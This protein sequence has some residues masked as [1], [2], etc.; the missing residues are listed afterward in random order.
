[1]SAGPGRIRLDLVG[2]EGPEHV[3][4]HID[5]LNYRL[6]KVR[7]GPEVA[8]GISDMIWYPDTRARAVSCDGMV[9]RYDGEWVVGPLW[10]SMAK[11]LALALS[12]V[13]VFAPT[14]AVVG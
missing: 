5:L 7:L 14:G 1:M 3:L 10:K 11:I 9:V 2:N 13:R 8:L 6:T 12:E 4:E